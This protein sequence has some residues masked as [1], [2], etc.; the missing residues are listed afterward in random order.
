MRGETTHQEAVRC[1]KEAGCCFEDPPCCHH[2]VDWHHRFEKAPQ[3]YR[4]GR[5]WC[6]GG[7]PVV[8]D[9]RCALAV[10]FFT[11]TGRRAA[12]ALSL[13][14]HMLNIVDWPLARR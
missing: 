2:V 8:A 1:Q 5:R 12:A 6:I 13:A 11:P 3:K 10:A 7:E 9:V 4:H 14:R